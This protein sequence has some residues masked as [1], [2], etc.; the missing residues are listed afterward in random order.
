MA[1]SRSED[2]KLSIPPNASEEE[3]AAI[4]AA[5]NAHLQDQRAAA[6]A[7]EEPDW[8]GKRWQFAGKVSQLQNRNVRVPRD[9]PTDAWAAAGRTTRF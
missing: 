9:A 2:V 1:T 6:E 5:I 3:A 8:D 7:D 4:A